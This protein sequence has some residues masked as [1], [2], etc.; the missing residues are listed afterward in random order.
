MCPPCL[1][2]HFG[3]KETDYCFNALLKTLPERG[4]E[5]ILIE[6][7]PD[8]LPGTYIKVLIQKAAQFILPTW[9]A[10]RGAVSSHNPHGQ[11]WVFPYFPLRT[12]IYVF[13]RVRDA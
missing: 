5:K 1:P 10:M 4:L 2:Q 9:L 12:D 11:F 7:G 3:I 8:K 13:D 6:S